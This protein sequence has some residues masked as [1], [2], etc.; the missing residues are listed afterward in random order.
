MRMTSLVVPVLAAASGA[1]QENRHKRWVMEYTGTETCLKCHEEEAEAFFHSQHYQWRG[2]TPA[3][4]NADGERLGKLT[5]IN[6]GGT[7]PCGPQ[8]IGKV[9]NDDG[10]VLAKGSSPCHAGLGLLQVG[11]RFQPAPQVFPLFDSRF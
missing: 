11:E 6:D 3:V 4:V 2:E 8:W 10:K 9:T 7:N 1:D 5:M